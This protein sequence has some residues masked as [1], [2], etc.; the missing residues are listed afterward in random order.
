VKVLETPIF[1]VRNKKETIYCYSQQE[2]KDAMKK[3]GAKPEIT[4]FKGL[5][6]ISPDEFAL[7]I[8][9][10]MRLL[11]I[12]LDDKI[13]IQELLKYYMGGNDKERQ[14]FILDNL[15][16]EIDEVEEEVL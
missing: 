1:R 3:L 4:R 9:K 15:I 16:Y 8:G 14:R 5:G 7:F 6:E 12:I 11:P 13:K 10:D 2:K